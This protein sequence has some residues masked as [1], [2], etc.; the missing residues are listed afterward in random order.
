MTPAAAGGDDP[1][2]WALI[3]DTNVVGGA[4]CVSW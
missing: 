4:A 1:T 2:A 3:N